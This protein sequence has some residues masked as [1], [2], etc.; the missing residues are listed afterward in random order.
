MSAAAYLSDEGRVG[1]GGTDVLGLVEVPV[2]VH[3]PLPVRTLSLVRPNRHTQLPSRHTLVVYTGN[4]ST[5]KLI[6]PT[7]ILSSSTQAMGQPTY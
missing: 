7:D 2:L 3:A 4:G 1:V 6:G 5:D